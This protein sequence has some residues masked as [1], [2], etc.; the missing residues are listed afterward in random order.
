MCLRWR[1]RLPSSVA[2]AEDGIRVAADRA[3]DAGMTGAVDAGMTGAVD[4]GMTGVVRVVR[5]A[6]LRGIALPHDPPLTHN[7]ASEHGGE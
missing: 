1:Q 5:A 7:P 4:A 6:E 2:D 3:E